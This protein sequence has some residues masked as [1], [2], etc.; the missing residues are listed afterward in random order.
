MLLSVFSSLFDALR[1]VFTRS[2]SYRLICGIL[3]GMILAVILP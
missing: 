3:V 1:P 2:A